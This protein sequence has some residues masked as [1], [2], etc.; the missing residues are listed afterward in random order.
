MK[1]EIKKYAYRII[2]SEEDQEFVGLC[3]EFPGLSWLEPDPDDALKGIRS[4]VK[5][6]V[7]DMVR[8]GEDIPLPISTREYS[9]KFIVRVPPEVHRNLAVEAAEAGVSLNRIV[10]ARLANQGG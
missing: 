3:A 7:D 9:G 1:T 6:C 8:T 10:S 2:W 5:E 4:V